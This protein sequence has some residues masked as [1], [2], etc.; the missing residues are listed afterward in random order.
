MG[1]IANEV[2][3]RNLASNFIN[4]NKE[5]EMNYSQKP[6]HELK[7]EVQDSSLDTNFN[8]KTG[9]SMNYS[10]DNRNEQLT[11]VQ[12][13]DSASNFNNLNQRNDM[14][15]SNTSLDKQQNNVQNNNSAS[16]FNNLNQRKDMN[17]S[18]ASID[19]QLNNVQNIDSAS[20]FNNLNQRKDMN[21]SN[22]SID[23]QQNNVQNSDS[24]SIFNNSYQEK[25]MNLSNASIDE[26]QNNV[27]NSDSASN[28]I[29]HFGE[30][31]TSKPI[32]QEQIKVIQDGVKTRNS[33]NKKSKIN[34][35]NYKN[36]LDIK[37]PYRNLNQINRFLSKKNEDIIAIDRN[38][39]PS[40]LSPSQELEFN[41]AGYY[42]SKTIALLVEFFQLDF[43]P[44]EIPETIAKRYIM[45]RAI[46]R[47][48]IQIDNE[49]KSLIHNS[50]QELPIISNNFLEIIKSGDNIDS[51]C[52]HDLYILIE[53]N[54]KYSYKINHDISTYFFKAA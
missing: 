31:R 42:D 46:V 16:N 32:N 18:N 9:G 38:S 33:D 20:N 43:I 6:H 45:S 48:L 5:N 22:A 40:T 13:N 53:R 23:E 27:Q 52:E 21:I 15:I 7:N 1:L 47:K 12:N 2:Q 34:M 50:N 10:D 37:L 25:D 29:H 4:S 35:K 54:N 14:N 3:D 49:Y 41:L 36:L 24:A 8:K 11:K 26:Q 51:I 17:I 44:N 39:S 28:L 19:E 30:K